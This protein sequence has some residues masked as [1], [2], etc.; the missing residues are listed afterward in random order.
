[1]PQ[2]K[3][4]TYSRIKQEI[5]APL[6]SGIQP[7]CFRV[8]IAMRA[9]LSTPAHP[10]FSDGVGVEPSSSLS[11][12]SNST[13]AH[14]QVTARYFL[15]ADGTLSVIV[16]NAGEIFVFQAARPIKV[17]VCDAAPAP[18]V[19]APFPVVECFRASLHIFVGL[20]RTWN[21]KLSSGVWSGQLNLAI[22]SLML[23]PLSV[24]I[25]TQVGS[26]R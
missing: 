15:V 23:P 25:G 22:T 1:M 9:D 26:S 13:A 21:Q 20:K 11:R 8:Y 6:Q 12:R 5:Q 24:P 18:V 14:Y 10:P 3:F 7:N 2:H 17:L 4:S 19:T 16:S